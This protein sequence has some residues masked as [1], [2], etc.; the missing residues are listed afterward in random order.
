[1]ISRSDKMV[2]W[3]CW[4]CFNKFWAVIWIF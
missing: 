2:N 4:N 3:C 1:M